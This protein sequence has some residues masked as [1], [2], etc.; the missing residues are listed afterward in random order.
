MNIDVLFEDSYIG[1]VE[2]YIKKDLWEY[3]Q[4]KPWPKQITKI[5]GELFRHYELRECFGII[6]YN[7]FVSI[8]DKIDKEQIF[9]E[10]LAEDDGVWFRKNARTSANI[11]WL[12]TVDEIVYHA[13]KWWNE[14]S[15]EA[16]DVTHNFHYRK[17]DIKKIKASIKIR[18][19]A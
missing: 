8:S 1:T 11:H 15:I 10:I 4:A 3:G 18:E 13:K 19:D 12:D 7:Q 2:L 17:A 6:I 14:H 9:F 16:F 5:D